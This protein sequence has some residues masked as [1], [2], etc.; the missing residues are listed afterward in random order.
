MTLLVIYLVVLM[1]IELVLL[2]ESK[3]V[4]ELVL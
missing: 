4:I 3:W 2:L 1:V